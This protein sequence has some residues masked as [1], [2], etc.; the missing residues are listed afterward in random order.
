MCDSESLGRVPANILS[1]TEQHWTPC[2]WW[3]V[4][5]EAQGPV[6]GKVVIPALEESSSFD[7][8]HCG[9]HT[10]LS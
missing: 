3:L 1:V 7:R 6:H 5:V 10:S 9:Y 2:S 8:A 4:L